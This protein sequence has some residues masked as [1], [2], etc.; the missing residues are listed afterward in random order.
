[1]NAEIQSSIMDSITK[2]FFKKI[3]SKFKTVSPTAN[4]IV[5][6]II[7]NDKKDNFI[8]VLLKT[9]IAQSF[10]SSGH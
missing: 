7:T 10:D 2:L 4:K 8:N 9:R 5:L 3:I 1:M 6:H